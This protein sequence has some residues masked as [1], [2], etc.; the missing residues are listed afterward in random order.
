MERYLPMLAVSAEPFDSAEYLFE[1]KWNGVRALAARADGPWLLWG[2]DRAEYQE[3]YPELAGLNRYDVGEILAAFLIEDRR[4]LRRRI[5]AGQVHP[6]ITLDRHDYVGQAP[7]FA[8]DD[9]L[10]RQGILVLSVALR[11]GAHLDFGHFGRF[12]VQRDTA[13]NA[14]E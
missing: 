9:R 1:V 7:I 12:A 5:V 13:A 8:D 6:F 2:R 14:F 10:L 3:R 11:H 4:D